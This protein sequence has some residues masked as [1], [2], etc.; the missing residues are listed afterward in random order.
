MNKNQIQRVAREL[1]EALERA[2]CYALFHKQIDALRLALIQTPR[3][4]QE[5]TLMDIQ[6]DTAKLILQYV[7]SIDAQENPNDSWF[8]PTELDAKRTS[9]HN[10]LLRELQ[11]AGITFRDRQE[12]TEWALKFARWW[13]DD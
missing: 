12:V 10:T 9:L 8:T 5:V 11:A 4:L 1:L 13:R 3:I 6:S 2:G 7:N